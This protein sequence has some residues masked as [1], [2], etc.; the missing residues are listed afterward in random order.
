MDTLKEK[1]FR[2]ER[3]NLGDEIT[4]TYNCAADPSK[5]PINIE[6][7]RNRNILVR[8]F[9]SILRLFAPLL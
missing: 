1:N 7:C 8:G 6:F 2:I 9:Q 5:D 4:Y 3:L